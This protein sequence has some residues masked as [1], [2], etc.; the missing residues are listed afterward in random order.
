[1]MTAFGFY[2]FLNWVVTGL[3]LPHLIKM[4]FGIES[5][6]TRSTFSVLNTTFFAGMLGLTYLCV[7]PILK[8]VYVLRCFYG[9]SLESGEDLRAELNSVVAASQ[10]IAAMV[11][12]LLGLLCAS[13]LKAADAPAAATSPAKTP[14]SSAVVTGGSGPRDQPDHPR[15]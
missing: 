15:R 5:V 13:P 8:T 2:V 11:V 12:L 14:V 1:M 7:D 10:P 6:F 4:L 9:E 3:M